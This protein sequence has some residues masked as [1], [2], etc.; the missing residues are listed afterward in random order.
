[1]ATSFGIK[2]LPLRK[3]LQLYDLIGSHIPEHV[4]GEHIIDFVGKIVNSIAEEKSTAYI[5]ALI[6]MT[7]DS[8]NVLQGF[9]SVTLLEMFTVGLTVNDII[10]LNKFCK[11]INYGN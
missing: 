7:G 2:P 10:G 6:L 4:E 3:A 5:D 11:E 1:M 9:S 8:L